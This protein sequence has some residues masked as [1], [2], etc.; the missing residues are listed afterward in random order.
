MVYVTELFGAEVNPI[1]TLL[2]SMKRAR[3]ALSTPGLALIHT[4]VPTVAFNSFPLGLVLGFVVPLALVLHLLTFRA[5]RLADRAGR[6][7]ASQA[8]LVAS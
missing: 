6:V 2:K 4:E 5:L 1:T 8:S 7:P 3:A